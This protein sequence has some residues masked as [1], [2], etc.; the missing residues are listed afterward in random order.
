MIAHTDVPYNTIVGIRKHMVHNTMI[1]VI[2][3]NINV[4]GVATLKKKLNIA[5]TMAAY[6]YG[7]L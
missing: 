4:Y 1:N 7:L 6:V 3:A 5:N 2:T